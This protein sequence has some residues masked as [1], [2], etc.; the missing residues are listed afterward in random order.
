MLYTWNI[1]N[2]TS[3][4]YINFFFFKEVLVFK[5]V[6]SS[7][8]WRAAF[9][10]PLTVWQVISNFFLKCEGH[11]GKANLILIKDFS[12]MTTGN[13]IQFQES[14]RKQILPQNWQ[15]TLADY[16]DLSLTIVRVENSAMLC[17]T[18][19]QQSYEQINKCCFKLKSKTTGDCSILQD[20]V[21]IIRV[22]LENAGTF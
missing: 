21:F 8:K 22:I 14:A 20:T 12:P 9:G 4:Y 13:W 6:K 7:Y 10:T 5:E 15:L 17:Q 3:Q 16:L 1:Y 2:V 11:Q 18:S 19:N